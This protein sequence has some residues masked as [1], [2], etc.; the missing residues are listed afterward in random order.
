[1]TFNESKN[2]YHYLHNFLN[3]TQI[4][5]FC[6]VTRDEFEYYMQTGKGKNKDKIESKLLSMKNMLVKQAKGVI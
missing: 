2:I 1:M 5:D 4:I 6:C 3:K